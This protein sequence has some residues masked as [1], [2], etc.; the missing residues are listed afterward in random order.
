MRINKYIAECGVASRRTADKLILDG[1]VSVN[2]KKITE[3]GVDV[4]DHDVVYFDGKRIRPVTRYS[5]LMLY[6]PKGCICSAKDD[7]GRKTI[8]D[9]VDLDKKL[10]I[11]GRLDYDSE[12]LLL[13]TN[14]GDVVNKI[15]H[16]SSEISK[17]YIVKVEGELS[18]DDIKLLSREMYIGRGEKSIG[19]KV[20]ILG[21]E[22]HIT[23][24]EI[25]ITEGKYREI[26]RMFE[27]IGKNVIFLKRIAIGEIRLGGLS[28]G[29]TRYL[30]DKEIAYLK[31]L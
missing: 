19:A 4:S 27:H 29:C 21:V 15:T 3:L 13:L 1:R 17:T 12:G 10:S 2:G 24:M 31:S 18:E 30:S 26:R 5:Y 9:Y 11:V 14:D 20:V 28:R 22:N 8:Y 6:K 7:R 25:S 16:P 23:R